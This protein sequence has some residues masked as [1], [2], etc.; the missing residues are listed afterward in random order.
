M[1]SAIVAYIRIKG[2]VERGE[3][4]LYRRK[5]WKQNERTKEKRERKENWYKQR[6][7]TKEKEF[8]SM[9]FVQPKVM[10]SAK[11]YHQDQFENSFGCNSC[12]LMQC[13]C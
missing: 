2:K 5:Q 10:V 8:K 6:N 4:P 13:I 1:R 3:R 11:S 7:K 9:L 12:F